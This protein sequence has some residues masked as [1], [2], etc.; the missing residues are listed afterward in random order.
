LA[1]LRTTDLTDDELVAARHYVQGTFAVDR[2]GLR[3]RAF[4]AALAPATNGPSD[5]SWLQG[6]AHVSKADVRRVAA[7]F[8]RHYAVGLIMPQG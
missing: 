5:L 2:E 4:G 3:E 6:V 1:K 8:S 7:N